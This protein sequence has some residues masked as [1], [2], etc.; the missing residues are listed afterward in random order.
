MIKLLQINV[1]ANW[2]S[3]GR[4]AEAINKKAKE[5]GWE[6][7]IA[8]GRN[9][10]PSDSTLIKVGNTIDVYSHYLENKLFDN[11]GLASRKATDKLIQQIK[12]LSPDI[13]HLHNIHDHWINYKILFDFF[14]TID[15]PIVWT[16]HDCWAFTGGCCYYSLSKCNKWQSECKNCIRRRNR[17][18][19]QSNKHFKLKRQIFQYINNLTV[20]PVSSWLEREVRQ[21]LL[22]KFPIVTIH[23]GVDI[24]VFKPIESTSVRTKYNINNKFFLVAV[25][26]IW[27]RRKGFNDYIALANLL[28]PDCVLMMIGLTNKMIDELPDNIIGIP[29]TSNTNELVNIY[30]EAD[31][32]LNLSY[33]ET[34]GLT[35]VEGM[36][37]GTPAI[38]YNVT[39]SPELIT[40]G[41]GAVASVGNIHEV[42]EHINTIKRIGS[43]YYSNKC[44]KHVVDN[45]NLDSCFEKYIQLYC[46]LLNTHKQTPIRISSESY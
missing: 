10:N 12:E 41:T 30:S 24:D 32:V 27:S 13:I 45:Y 37:C 29:A 14:A 25:A 26:N 36:A 42:L 5:K 43:H 46:E 44:R 39:A 18:F 8:Y 33:E 20:V 11:E 15:T 31:V 38:V 3:T 7:Y 22:S 28:S 40:T 2:G 16:Q 1:T 35:T 21:S 23:N 6:C 19:D 34:F 17:L 9:S 4:I